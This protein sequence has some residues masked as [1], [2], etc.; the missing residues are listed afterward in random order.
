MHFSQALDAAVL[1]VTDDEVL[2]VAEQNGRLST[3][4]GRHARTGDHPVTKDTQRN[5]FLRVLIPDVLSFT[6]TQL[7]QFA[8]SAVVHEENCVLT[9]FRRNGMLQVQQVIR[10]D[11]AG[12]L[13]NYFP[14]KLVDNAQRL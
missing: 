12:L 1:A 2:E 14:L 4:N 9:I 5:L 6:G 13:R 8:Q 11:L 7:E 3:L 10:A